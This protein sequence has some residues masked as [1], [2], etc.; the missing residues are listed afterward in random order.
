VNLLLEDIYYT[1]DEFNLKY[2]IEFDIDTIRFK[3][4]K[5]HLGKKLDK[6]GQWVKLAKNNHMLIKAQKREKNL[7]ITSIYSLEKYNIHRYYFQDPPKYKKAKLVIFGLKQYYKNMNVKKNPQKMIDNVV[8]VIYNSVKS[9]KNSIEIDV[10]WDM[11]YR[12]KLKKLEK[13][14]E[15]KQY[16]TDKGVKTDTYYINSPNLLG[17]N[18]IVIYNKTSKD[19]LE[20]T[21]HRIEATI[22]IYNPRDIYLPLDDFLREFIMPIKRPKF[23]D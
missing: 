22:S 1:L 16:I 9:N 13:H 20:Q 6:V 17:I 15:L 4:N 18:R 3:Y 23:Y 8:S 19:D 14:Y 10:C 2:Q 5:T 12:P 21:L 11:P 7:K